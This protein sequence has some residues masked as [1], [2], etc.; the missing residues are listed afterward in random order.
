MKEFMLW[1]S[2]ICYLDSVIFC[3]V[4]F[5]LYLFAYLYLFMNLSYYFQIAI[6]F[7]FKFISCI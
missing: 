6:H 3:S 4:C 5:I 2:C 1:N 7:T